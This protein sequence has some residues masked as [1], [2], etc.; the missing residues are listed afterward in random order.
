MKH[1]PR[2]VERL[3]AAGAAKLAWYAPHYLGVDVAA[4]IAD[5]H[6]KRREAGGRSADWLAAYPPSR[7]PP[8]RWRPAAPV[9]SEVEGPPGHGAP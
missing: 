9:L 6:A 7:L 3:L 1:R 5:A 4:L 8:F 2:G